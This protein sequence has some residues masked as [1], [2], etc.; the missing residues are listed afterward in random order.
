MSCQHFFLALHEVAEVV[1]VPE[2]RGRLVPGLGVPRA[3]V[4]FSGPFFADTRLSP[5]PPARSET[6]L[7]APVR[8]LMV[9]AVPG[10]SIAALAGTPKVRT[11]A[12]SQGDGVAC[13][14]GWDDA[15]PSPRRRVEG[16][17]FSV[18]RLGRALERDYGA[19]RRS[20]II[21]FAPTTH[22]GTATAS[23]R[24]AL[25][26][27]RRGLGLPSARHEGARAVRQNRCCQNSPKIKPASGPRRP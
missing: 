2:L 27:R 19:P 11:V 7:L 20:T 18:A 14:T 3:A 4:L 17:I 15:V 22:V 16:I 8:L 13:K 25:R 9:V 6:V 23:R 21:P 12:T 1:R 26:A 10:R 5:C 24:R